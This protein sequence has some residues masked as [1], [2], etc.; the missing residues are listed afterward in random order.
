MRPEGPGGTGPSIGARPLDSQPATRA[1]H[2]TWRSLR[3]QSGT[4]AAGTQTEVSGSRITR[5]AD[6][7]SS[8]SQET[9]SGVP[10]AASAS[11]FRPRTPTPPERRVGSPPL[12]ASRRSAAPRNRSPTAARAALRD[13]AGLTARPD[14]AGGSG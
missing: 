9:S 8:S 10:A 4:V 11:R 2:C 1:S 3:R 7:S 12:I 13:R 14:G 5:P 6:A